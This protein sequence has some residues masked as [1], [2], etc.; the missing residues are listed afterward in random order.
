M[1]WF[2]KPSLGY[3]VNARLFVHGRL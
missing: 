1:K 3:F 2:V